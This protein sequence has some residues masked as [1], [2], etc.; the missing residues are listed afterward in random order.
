MKSNFFLVFFKKVED[1]VIFPVSR[2]GFFFENA[3]SVRNRT[4]R[5]WTFT[6]MVIDP[7]TLKPYPIF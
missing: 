4:Y 5:S 3:V 1:I 6:Q 7:T 2:A